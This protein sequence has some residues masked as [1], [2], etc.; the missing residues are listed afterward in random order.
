MPKT[1]SLRKM[2]AE[3]FFIDILYPI[4]KVPNLFLIL[5]LFLFLILSFPTLPRVSVCFHHEYV[6]NFVKCIFCVF[7]DD[8]L[9]FLLSSVSCCIV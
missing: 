2:L 7:G 5:I 3:V 8:S 4:R 1:L 6:L 9:I